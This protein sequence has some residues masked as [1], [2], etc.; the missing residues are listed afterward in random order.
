MGLGSGER[1]SFVHEFSIQ[2]I[3]PEHLSDVRGGRCCTADVGLDN[4]RQLRV[5]A[6]IVQIWKC[7]VGKM[8]FLWYRMA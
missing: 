7:R 1:G 2:G 6:Q 8:I 3:G 4:F 5:M